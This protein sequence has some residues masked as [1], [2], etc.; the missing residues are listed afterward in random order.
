MLRQP[1]A[2]LRSVI[3]KTTAEGLR[4]RD[5]CRFWPFCAQDSKSWQFSWIRIGPTAHCG[6]RTQP[7]A[8]RGCCGEERGMGW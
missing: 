7:H 1:H 3:A 6:F 4:N 8:V 5:D 2:H